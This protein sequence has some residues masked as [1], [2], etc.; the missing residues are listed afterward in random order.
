MNGK[1]NIGHWPFRGPCSPVESSGLALAVTLSLQLQGWGEPMLLCADLSWAGESGFPGVTSIPFSRSPTGTHRRSSPGTWG[2]DSAHRHVDLVSLAQEQAVSSPPLIRLPTK[3]VSA[4]RFPGSLEAGAWGRLLHDRA[5]PQR[6]KPSPHF[7]CFCWELSAET[8]ML[9]ALELF[10]ALGPQKS[11][12]T[13][14]PCP[15]K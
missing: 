9:A 7:L 13:N 15:Q 6:Q 14:A 4:P 11:T 10:V 1:S 5:C 12:L 8:Q 3:G 2:Q